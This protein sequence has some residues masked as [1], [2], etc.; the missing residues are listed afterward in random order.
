MKRWILL[1]LVAISCV[2]EYPVNIDQKS[3]QLVVDGMIT[4]QLIQQEVKLSITTKIKILKSVSGAKINLFDENGFVSEMP[5]SEVVPGTYVTPVALKGKIGSSYW[6]EI[7][8]SDGRK[9]KSAPDTMNEEIK[10][11]K[12]Y[13]NFNYDEN[14]FDVFTEALTDESQLP[15]LRWKRFG[16]Y[17]RETE[18]CDCYVSEFESSLV[19]AEQA[20][21]GQRIFK[22]KAAFIPVSEERFTEK[23]YINIS[24]MN[25]SASAFAFWKKAENQ[26]N[27]ASNFFQPVLGG[28]PGNIKSVDNAEEQVLG[29][30]Y[31]AN[32]SEH[33]LFI[34][35]LDIPYEIDK[36]IRRGECKGITNGSLIR[37]PFWE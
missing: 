36:P 14:G 31:A 28:V 35:R 1:V 29:L 23:Y 6:I 9:Y 15:Y 33:G 37:P 7:Q 26:A 22:V 4:T 11:N 13:F 2:D 3:G 27:A 18:C 34:D 32:V 12:V 5:E 19:M 10:I 21:V 8:T 16:T 17:L 20:F 30:F 24:Q 25:L